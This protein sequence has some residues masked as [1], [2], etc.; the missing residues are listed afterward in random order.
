MEV[1][2]IQAGE[3]AVL[4]EAR[5]RALA[6]APL[7]FGSTLAEMQ[8]QPL[9]Y[10]QQRAAKAAAGDEQALFIAIDDGRWLGMAGGVMEPERPGTGAVISMWVDPLAR[11]AGFALELLAVVS[12][13][14]ARR[15]AERLELWV[16][17]S[18]S[19]ARA[20]Y[21]RAGFAE[22]GGR[23]PL[24]SHPWLDEIE[25]AKALPPPDAAPARMREE[26][27]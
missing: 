4:R 12:A 5:L 20:L 10:W 6:D 8:A 21:R 19:A 15:G 7:A 2:R 1:R 17:E 9:A 22:T 25:M 24:P 23:Q 18:N 16:T 27:R 13:W 26:R 11:R 3:G 14:C